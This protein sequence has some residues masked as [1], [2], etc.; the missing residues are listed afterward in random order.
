MAL[1]TFICMSVTWMSNVYAR[2]VVD[3]QLKNQ[4]KSWRDSV[5]LAIVVRTWRILKSIF[6][7]ITSKKG[8]KQLKQEKSCVEF[9]AEMSL[10]NVSTR[11]GSPDS[12]MVIFQSK[13]FISPVGFPRLTTIKWK[14]W[15]KQI[16]IQ[17]FGTCYCSKSIRWKCSWPFEIARLRKVAWRLGTAWVE[18]NSSDESHKRLQSNAKKTIRSWS[19]WSGDEKWIVYNN[20][21][22]KRS[23]SKRGEVPERQAKAKIHQKKVM[24]SM[25]WDWKGSVFYELLPKNKTINSDVYCEQLQKLSEVIAQKRPELINRKGVVFHYDNARPHTSLVIRQKL[26]QH[27][28]MCYHIH[29]ITQTL[30][31]QTSISFAPYK[32]P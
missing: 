12:I 22:R 1:S 18:R 3:T 7:F 20:V 29:R 27:V 30:H 4:K 31:H 11:T 6:C 8:R 5:V 13:T 23:W 32:T 25:W 9:T 17:R 16:S 21:S 19:I 24:L 15:C 10:K 14:H 2:F 26:L 28:R